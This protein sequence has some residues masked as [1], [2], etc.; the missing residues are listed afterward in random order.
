VLIEDFVNHRLCGEFATDYS[1]ASTTL[2]F[3][4]KSR[5][6]SDELIDRGGID[7]RLLC[8]PHPAGTVLG[9][10]HDKAAAET[11]LAA[12]TPVVLGGHDYCCGCLPTG[13]FKPGVVLD[14]LGTWEMVVATLDEP[15]LTTA[16]LE[17]GVLVDC[18]VARD[19]FTV[20]GATV[21][22]DMLEWFKRE[23]GGGESERAGGGDG[24]TWDLLVELAGQSPAGSNGVFFLPHM[25]GSHCPVLDPKSAGT[26]AG[27]R[28]TS[29]RADLMRSIIEG[30][31]YQSHQIVR[32]FERNMSVTSDDIVAI[33]G[34]T[35]NELLMQ[36]KADLIGKPV[37]VPEVEE[38]VPLG[39]AILAGIGAG[40]YQGEEEAF[41]QVNRE[42]K[43]YRP[44][45]ESHQRYRELY[46]HYEKL[47]PS[48]REFYRG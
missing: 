46:A 16:G 8:P 2:L 45:P 17:M 23:L 1:M 28:N 19:K 43:L 21:S 18:H 29:T 14:V 15:V 6:W 9:E 4:L 30:I 48:I 37:R 24:A 25:S 39:A 5:S 3:D 31:S 22:A 35:N 41:G 12:G 42:G 11:G 40:V 10:V 32:A 34:P 7:G 44:V 20:M 36:T 38:S 33:G 13:A 47:Y 27:L 26:F